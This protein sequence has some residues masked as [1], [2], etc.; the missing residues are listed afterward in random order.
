LPVTAHTRVMIRKI[1]HVG[2]FA[3]GIPRR[4]NPMAGIAGEAL[5]F[6]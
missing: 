2:K 5:M 4:G 1:G 3:F 6:L